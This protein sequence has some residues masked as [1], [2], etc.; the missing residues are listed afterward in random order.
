MPTT[1]PHPFFVPDVR[2]APALKNDVSQFVKDFLVAGLHNTLVEYGCGPFEIDA[3]IEWYW[4]ESKFWRAATYPEFVTVARKKLSDRL[5][6]T[7]R[8]NEAATT[9][10]RLFDK[11]MYMQVSIDDV[12]AAVN[13]LAPTEPM[14]NE[15]FT[16]EHAAIVDVT[17]RPTTPRLLKVEADFLSTLQK[18]YP[19]RREDDRIVKSIP[20]SRDVDLCVFAFWKIHPD[21][22]PREFEV[23]RVFRNGDRLD[24]TRDNLRSRWRDKA[25]SLKGCV[26]A[27]YY[28]PMTSD[29]SVR[30]IHKG[31]VGL[32]D[33]IG[34]DPD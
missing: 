9:V 20:T 17:S 15:I 24:W 18:L 25:E 34:G 7:K 32:V 33:S 2:F 13:T 11:A 16:N 31:H 14:P 19:W 1:S 23:A 5:G 29:G 3:H 22:S 26:P 21:M 27:E 10:A 4:K 6:Y 30:H 8:R 28:E 12:V